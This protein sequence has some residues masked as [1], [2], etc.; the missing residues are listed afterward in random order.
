MSDDLKNECFHL[1]LWYFAISAISGK[2]SINQYFSSDFV[3]LMKPMIK[4]IVKR[5]A[6]AKAD[7]VFLS[8]DYK[9]LFLEVTSEIKKIIMILKQYCLSIDSKIMLDEEQ[10]LEVISNTLK[11]QI[12]DIEQLLLFKRVSVLHLMFS[13][14]FGLYLKACLSFC[15]SPKKIVRIY[16]YY[17]IRSTPLNNEPRCLLEVFK[18]ALNIW[19]NCNVYFEFIASIFLLLQKISFSATQYRDEDECSLI[20]ILEKFTDSPNFEKLICIDPSLK[21][22]FNCFPLDVIQGIVKNKLKSKSYCDLCIIC[23]FLTNE[24]YDEVYNLLKNSVPTIYNCNHSIKKAMRTSLSNLSL[25]APKKDL[26]N[27]INLIIF[28]LKKYNMT[29]SIIYIYSKFLVSYYLETDTTLN[30]DLLNELLLIYKYNENIKDLAFDIQNIVEAICSNPT[31][32]LDILLDKSIQTNIL[33]K[34]LKGHKNKN[35]LI[36]LITEPKSFP[37]ISNDFLNKLI[38]TIKES[39]EKTDKT[40]IFN[41]LCIEM[42]SFISLYPR[43]IDNVLDFGED[44]NYKYAEFFYI[45]ILQSKTRTDKEELFQKFIKTKYHCMYPNLVK[46]MNNLF[47]KSET[48][49]SFSQFFELGSINNIILSLLFEHVI[50]SERSEVLVIFK[51][52]NLTPSLWFLCHLNSLF[53]SLVIN[54]NDLICEIKN[55]L[56]R[57]KIEELV[58]YVYILFCKLL[59][60]IRKCIVNED[61]NSLTKILYYPLINFTLTQNDKEIIKQFNTQY[62]VFQKISKFLDQYTNLKT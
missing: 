45:A 22:Y 4:K 28:S 48:C 38:K 35:S 41:Y 15:Q 16:G 26:N 33:L 39:D 59:P 10:S 50:Y 43:E 13:S 31:R 36:C 2:A 42:P 30:I 37:L 24:S 46:D 29:N 53:S 11:S 20:Q 23:K 55:S 3:A 54:Q 21:I 44:Y 14:K 9:N 5:N 25:S 58:W 32:L 49:P 19:E 60:S 57:N 34:F 8:S 61:I 7:E 47:T 12:F 1:D 6:F 18:H 56:K 52:L 27:I 51:R 62:N 40:I 17:M